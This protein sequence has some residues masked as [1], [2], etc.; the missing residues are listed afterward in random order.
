M[1]QQIFTEV[2]P[3]LA[4]VPPLGA[5]RLRGP[6]A[7]DA[8][9]ARIA[10]RLGKALSGR[11]V[12]SEGVLLTDVP[13]SPVQVDI[14]LDMLRDQNADLL[15][16]I[17]GVDEDARWAITPVAHA[18]YLMQTVVRDVEEEILSA[19]LN[20][21]NITPTVRVV[22]EPFYRAWAVGDEP[23][24][25][26]SIRSHLLY[27]QNLHEWM[28]T[29]NEKIRQYI[30]WQVMDRT[31]MT[32][33]GTIT[34]TTGV[35]AQHRLRLLELTK[36]PVM[37]QLLTESPDTTLVFRVQS[38]HYEYEYAATA[39]HALITPDNNELLERFE[40]T[41]PF[42]CRALRLSPVLRAAQVKTIADLLKA[43][44]IIGNSYNARTHPD[45]FSQLEAL[46]DLEY[47]QQ[48]TR[49][50]SLRNAGDDLLKSGLYRRHPRYDQAPIRI[51]TINAL[52]STVDDFVEAL[53]RRIEKDFGLTIHIIKERKVRVVT[54]RNIESAVRL[55]EKEA[56]D[57]VLAFFDDQQATTTD[58]DQ[59]AR[60]L[61][62]LTL[63][64]GIATQV[65]YEK[66][67]NDPA[68][69]PLLIRSL[70]ARTGST[71]YVFAQ[72]LEW[73]DYVVGIGVL[74]ETLSK[75][76]RLTGLARIYAANG[77]FSHYISETLDLDQGEAIPMVLLQTLLPQATFGGKRVIVHH[78]GKVTADLAKLVRKWADILKA[79]ITLVEIDNTRS[80]RLYGLDK[81]V[82][83]PAWSSIFLLDTCTAALVTRVPLEDATAQPLLVRVVSGQLPVTHAAYTVLLWT[84]LHYSP[85]PASEL[86]VTVIY[87]DQMKEW[88]ARGGLPNLPAHD[89]P[90]WL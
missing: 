57:I 78:Q 6:G 86:P 64:K 13:V 30:G 5:Y 32:M 50:F 46:P 8:A 74:R 83:Q 63:A 41:R 69:M 59:Q 70:L 10:Y 33:I 62:A 60:T 9:G 48:R 40:L 22:R 55:I 44:N 77:M 4:E 28:H 7:D 61:K 36:R 82:I 12:W 90:F 17:S 79:D 11:W 35:L 27:S 84:L 73:A 18:H 80:P 65:I 15:A 47:G 14:T 25:S 51:A 1:S 20:M 66:A 38:G 26:V 58:D 31:T 56:P 76:D 19:V 88:L 52:D 89:V 49:P 67:I 68:Q 21:A 45:L 85:S 23:A 29:R 2:F 87:A 54:P 42:V 37:Q 43:H 53:R 24:L 34:G 72:P 39:L 16:G 81:G 75:G 71:P 3:I